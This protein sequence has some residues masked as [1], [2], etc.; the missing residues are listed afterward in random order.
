MNHLHSK[1]PCSYGRYWGYVTNRTN[2]ICPYVGVVG[3]QNYYFSGKLAIGLSLII[4]LGGDKQK[5]SSSACWLAPTS[6]QI[7]DACVFLYR[8]LCW[9]ESFN[10]SFEGKNW[11][12]VRLNEEFS[13]TVRQLGSALRLFLFRITFPTEYHW[14][15]WDESRKHD[16]QLLTS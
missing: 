8:G 5:F 10:I 12:P 16:T 7:W 4:F 15:I 14:F 1:I 6:L 9:E 11:S 3:R 2:N 13:D